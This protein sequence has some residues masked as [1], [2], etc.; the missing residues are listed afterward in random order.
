M[1]MTMAALKILSV[2][3]IDDNEWFGDEP[4]LNFN[5]QKIWSADM[6]QGQTLPVN[7]APFVFDGS[8][9]LSFWENDGDHW[10]DRNDHLGTET[11]HDFQAPG[12]AFSL[13]FD[14]DG[15]YKVMVDIV[16]VTIGT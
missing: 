2:E 14:D 4:Y 12:G 1:K 3:C 10:W 13:K 6:S 8:A 7:S 5:G 9:N 11:V 15:H 16:P